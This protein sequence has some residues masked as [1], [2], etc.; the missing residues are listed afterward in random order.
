MF[1]V[2]ECGGAEREDRGADLS[3]GDDLDA[4]DIGEAGAAVIAKGAEYEILPFLIEDQDAGEHSR[5]GEGMDQQWWWSG[6]LRAMGS[7]RCLALV[8][9]VTPMLLYFMQ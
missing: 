2:T 7:S 4:K 3:I 5:D 6:T 9:R 8:R 1:D